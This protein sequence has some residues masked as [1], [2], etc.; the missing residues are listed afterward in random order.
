MR[1]F[2]FLLISLASTVFFSQLSVAQV[3][4]EKFQFLKIGEVQP[5]GWLLDQIRMDATNGYGPVLDKLTDRI[6]ITTFDS[7]NKTELAKPK[8]GG[9]WWN[10]ETTGNWFDG[11]V[12]T[13]YLSGDAAAKMRVDK[14]AAQFL[15]MQDTDG[16][17][18]IYP[19]AKRFESP[20]VTQNGE[21]W[22]QA[23]LYRGLLAY[24]EL[25][26][27]A[28][29]LAAV[30]R[31]TKLMMSKYGPSKPYWA[32]RIMRGGPGHNIM[33]VDVCEWL[34]RLT[35][36]PSYVAFA[37]FLYDGYC[38][39]MDVRENDVQLRNLSDLSK[40]FHGHGAHVMEHI[41]I[42]LFLACTAGDPK[43]RA[44]ADNFFPKAV[45]HLVAGGACISDEDIL[46]RPGSPYIGCEYC[47]S[48]EFLH[49][50]QSGVEKSGRGPFADAIEVMAYNSAEGA[51]QRDGRAV[52]YC[53]VDNQYEATAKGIGRRAKLSPTHEDVALCCPVTALKFYPYFVNALWMKTA[54]GDGLVAVNYAPNELL[55]TIKGVKIRIQSETH[56][57]FEDEV[58]MMVT[59][60]TPA[61]FGIRLRIP[62]WAG[63]LSVAS[64]EA[65][66]AEVA[67][68][69]RR[70][71]R[72]TDESGWRVLTREWQAGDRISISFKP[73]IERKAMANGEVYWQRGPLVYAMPIAGEAKQIKTYPM[74]G[75][76]DYDYT[77]QAGAFWNYA[78]DDINGAFLFKTNTV[79]G[80]PWINPPVRLCGNLHNRKTGKSEPVELL[81]MGVHLLRRVA[82]P[83]LRAIRTLDGQNRVL[84]GKFNLARQARVEAS[85]TAKGY[86]PEALVDGIA[87]GFPENLAA[88]WASNRGTAGVKVKLTWQKPVTVESVWLF[89]RPNP[90]DHVQGARINFS[91]GTST[92]IGE[93]PND[94][95]APFRLN[96]P[97]KSVTWIEVIITQVGA[98]TRNAGFSEIAVFAKEPTL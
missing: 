45:R 5:R 65:N 97:E 31:A 17:L 35:G 22:T 48:L 92:M 12:R 83:E 1:Y 30:Q 26:G 34:Y 20:V 80:N 79:Q 23:C 40:P 8:I 25:T 60:E 51:R 15:A 96:F 62:G 53:T 44:A 63:T 82:F 74:A 2:I 98:K 50:L 67:T 61:T 58:R 37:R 33:F 3:A 88:E 64:P 29:V 36:D 4:R 38:E 6:E 39:P 75:F 87:Q 47:T 54:A 9:D 71:L 91:D 86:A 70:S 90:T 89:D 49:S 77:P 85:S 73:A 19:R 93:L 76:A 7:R 16:Y 59:P 72:I 43:Y 46:G 84:Q 13:A 21:F 78:V 24:H 69:S 95:T 81:P 41:R 55:T 11:L 18:G 57:P 68:E 10:G 56:Y 27:R 32:R 28:E 14:L 94:A 52:Q 42:P 66:R